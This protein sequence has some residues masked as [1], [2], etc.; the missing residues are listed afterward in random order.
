MNVTLDTSAIVPSAPAVLPKEM[1]THSVLPDGRDH[2][3]IN[4]SSLSVMQECWRKV[5]YSLVRGL[6]PQLESPATLFGSAIHKG[7][8][9]FYRG[10][11]TERKLP[12]RYA[13]IME[14]IG[15]GHWEPEWADN[16][17]L[18]AARSFVL[19]AAPLSALADDNKRSIHTGVWMLRHYFERYLTDEYVIMEDAQG[20]IVER[21]FSMEILSDLQMVIEAFGTIDFVMKSDVTGLILPGDHKT[22]SSLYQFYDMVSPNFQYTMY[23]WAARKVLGVESDCFLVNALEVKA[24]PKTAKGSPPNFIR[25]VTTRTQEHYDE[26]KD[27]IT[28]ACLIYRANKKADTW[29][30]AS[31]GPCTG[32]YGTCQYHEVCSAPLALKENIISAKFQQTGHQA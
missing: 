27:A 18:S 31:P 26:L 21:S 20:P 19:K 7:L 16:L 5:Q 22:S 23:S 10:K 17:L 14:Q 1:L 6:R 11:R 3:R 28:L 30:M 2:F 9:T 13:E 8:E 4:F 15:C 12:T 25:Q 29:P 24:P 32:K